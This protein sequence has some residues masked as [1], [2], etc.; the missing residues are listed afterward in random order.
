MYNMQNG[1]PGDRRFGYMAY[2]QAD[3][4]QVHLCV[5]VNVLPQLLCAYVYTHAP[6]LLASCGCQG[7]RT[8]TYQSW[9]HVASPLRANLRTGAYVL[10][11]TARKCR[12]PPCLQA[13]LCMHVCTLVGPRKLRYGYMH[14]FQ[15]H[16]EMHA[17]SCLY[18]LVCKCIHA[19]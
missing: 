19:S 3:S 14:V 9:W 18:L 17:P 1:A 5:I 8:C 11:C 16:W 10:K 12:H 13:Y 15:Q 7:I 4:A 2:V 6:C